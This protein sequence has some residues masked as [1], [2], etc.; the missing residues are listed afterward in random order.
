[1]G[2]IKLC[3][4]IP[5]GEWISREINFDL[6][7]KYRSIG[8]THMCI[9]RPYELFSFVNIFLKES[10]LFIW[11]GSAISLFSTRAFAAPAVNIAPC[12]MI[13]AYGLSKSPDGGATGLP[14]I[15]R[16]GPTCVTSKAPGYFLPRIKNT[17]KH[18]KANGTKIYFLFHD[19]NYFDTKI[20]K[21]LVPW[22]KTE[23]RRSSWLVDPK[24]PHLTVAQH[25]CVLAVFPVYFNS[26]NRSY[27][28]WVFPNMVQS[29]VTY[30][31][32]KIATMARLE[33]LGICVGLL[34]CISD[35]FSQNIIRKGEWNTIVVIVLSHSRECIPWK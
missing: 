25:R 14:G 12:K 30:L 9:Q 33:T 3:K 27:L 19:M 5:Y 22:W 13:K 11:G 1:M 23:C 6:L 2:L 34:L 20:T 26:V 15:T 18:S 28:S 32:W 16:S 7:N 35:V 8:L 17:I 31:S 10:L 29:F 4:N 21:D 24:F